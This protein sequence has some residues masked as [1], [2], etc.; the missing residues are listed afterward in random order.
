[1]ARLSTGRLAVL[2]V[3]AR[4][5]VVGLVGIQRGENH[6]F[7][8]RGRG[9]G[10]SGSAR[11]SA[12]ATGDRLEATFAPLAGTA[13]G[14]LQAVGMI[15]APSVGP[16]PRTGAQLGARFRGLGVLGPVVRLD[17]GDQA[18]TDMDAQ[19]T[20]AAAVVCGAAGAD[21]ACLDGSPPY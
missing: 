2:A 8:L 10:A 13:H 5:V 18:I 4:E 17:A 14:S 16:A 6:R 7:E 20:A 15:L 11:K 19:E 9:V 3:L 12:K 1:M 21:D